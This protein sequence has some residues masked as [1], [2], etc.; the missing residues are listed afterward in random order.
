MKPPFA[1]IKIP[2]PG[3]VEVMSGLMPGSKVQPT[4]QSCPT[5]VSFCGWM[6]NPL[7]AG[8]VSTVP[9]FPAKT[10]TSSK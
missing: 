6:V 1:S 4:K 7:P 9:I 2:G 5:S 3:E 10:V 8:P